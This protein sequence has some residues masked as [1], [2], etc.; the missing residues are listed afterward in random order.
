V[1]SLL[2]LVG[3]PLVWAKANS[4]P[5]SN[6][7]IWV[8][9][10][11]SPAHRNELLRTLK[12]ITGLLD[13]NFERG[14]SL[15]LGSREAAKGSTSARELLVAATFGERVIVI[16]DASSRRDIAF[17]KVV[18]GKW[19]HA[20]NDKLPAFVVLIDFTDFEKIT[21]DEK[22]RAA[23]DV[24][25]GFLHE[26]DHVTN[27]S[28]D[29]EVFG[30]AGECEDHINKMRQ[31]LD[32]PVRT[33]YFFSSTSFRSDPN[34]STRFVSLSFEHIDRL[35]NKTR[36]YRLTWDSNLVGGVNGNGQTA[37]VV[38]SPSH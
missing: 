14:G 29:S 34:F 10:N 9:D 28:V 36:Q 15:Q 17:C 21:G 24:G 26:L 2:A 25:W 35:T 8:R 32:V 31:E 16:E 38:R 30:V 11:V 23:F 33:N 7:H 22:A 27:D 18:P 13:L 12:R 37:L 1:V 19:L 6:S 4:A 3:Y 5:K 20:A